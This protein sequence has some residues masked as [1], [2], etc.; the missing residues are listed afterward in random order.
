MDTSIAEV[1]KDFVVLWS[2]REAHGVSVQITILSEEKFTAHLMMSFSR[3]KQ[4][5]HL[6]SFSLSSAFCTDF[7]M[8]FV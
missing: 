4:K 2:S 8:T 1:I 7:D 5:S 6:G 3:R